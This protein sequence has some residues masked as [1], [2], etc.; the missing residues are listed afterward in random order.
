MANITGSLAVHKVVVGGL[1]CE[2]IFFPALILLSG[3]SVLESLPTYE[4]RDHLTG[5]TLTCTKCPPGTYMAAHCSA[6]TDTKCAPCSEDHFTALWNYLPRCLY[7]S[8][9]CSDNQEVE[10]E[11]SATG[12][13]ECR[14]KEGHYWIGH[15]CVR[16]AACAPGYGVKTAG[17]AQMNTVCE[18]CAEGSFSSSSSALDPCV[19]HKECAAG[20][21]A[22]LN[23]SISHNTVCGTCDD[24]VNG[25]G[26]YRAFLFG[27]FHGREVRIPKMRRFVTRY[28][29]KSRAGRRVRGKALSLQRGLFLDQIG[30]WLNQAPKKELKNLPEMLRVTGLCATA[31]KLQSRL[32]EIG[33][34]H[35]NCTLV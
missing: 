7:C 23:C 25:G 22:L 26:T 30:S 29:H 16:H 9:F 4:H 20:E 35:P 33:Q 32:R 27:L 15:F 28:I 12:N 1:L 24:V 18:R 14:C 17:T 11:C 2:R 10:S 3:A 8:N 13:R 19:K 6:T 5:E 31:E 21:I 34:Q